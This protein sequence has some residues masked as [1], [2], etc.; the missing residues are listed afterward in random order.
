ME[1]IIL[2]RLLNTFRQIM[3][4]MYANIN[5]H[6]SQP[7]EACENTKLNDVT[8]CD[9]KRLNMLKLSIYLFLTHNNIVCIKAHT[10]P[11]RE[12]FHE[13]VIK[14]EVKIQVTMIYYDMLMIFRANRLIP[15][16]EG[17]LLLSIISTV[18]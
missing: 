13:I 11:Q 6:N 17:K 8:W 12:A 1:I 5:P 9:V 15:V 14:R 18:M 16:R 4:C 10:Y 3:P 2:W 7:E